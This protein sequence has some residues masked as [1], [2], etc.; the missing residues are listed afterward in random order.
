MATRQ[1]RFHLVS[2]N[3]ITVDR[4]GGSSRPGDWEAEEHH[5]VADYAA[6]TREKAH[7]QRGRKVFS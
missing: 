6:D 4:T 3:L 7:Q 2:E 1:G 5:F